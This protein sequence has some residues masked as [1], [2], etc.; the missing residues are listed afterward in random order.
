MISC[1]PVDVP[2]QM[3]VECE[4]SM[5]T[6]ELKVEDSTYSLTCLGVLFVFLKAISS[7]RDIHYLQGSHHARLRSGHIETACI[8]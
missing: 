6:A 5:S 3:I 1:P 2:K 8:S 7:R 4:A